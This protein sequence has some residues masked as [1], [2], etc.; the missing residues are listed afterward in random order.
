V[1]VFL[2]ALFTSL[3]DVGEPSGTPTATA[4]ASAR[5]PGTKATAKAAAEE[6]A[7]AASGTKTTPKPK[8]TTKPKSAPA[9]VAPA[10]APTDCARATAAEVAK[11]LGRGVKPVATRTGCA[12]GTRLDDPSTV[13]VSITLSADHGSFDTQLQTSVKQRR[14]VYGTAYGP[15]YRPATALWVATGQPISTATGS[16][17]ALADT[18]I[19]IST[20][21]LGLTDDQ[22]RRTAL[23]IAAALTN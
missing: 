16:V 7:K 1:P 2:T 17:K 5:E 10:L 18:H 22:A 3:A 15:R 9:L 21:E 4:T 6:T 12:W 14:V 8:T 23:T 20:T 11:A 19:V 13:L